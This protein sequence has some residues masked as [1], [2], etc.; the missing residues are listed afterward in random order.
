MLEISNFP[1][2]YSYEY[3]QD[4]N[5]D[6]MSFRRVICDFLEEDDFVNLTDQNGVPFD[7]EF[8]GT[9]KTWKRKMLRNGVHCDHIFQ[10]LTADYLQRNIVLVSALSKDGHDESGE[11]RIKS[12]YPVINNEPLY[13]LYYHEGSFKAG[14]FQSIRPINGNL[15][16]DPKKIHQQREKSFH[17]DVCF[18]RF[19]TSINLKA[20]M[21]THKGIK[22]FKCVFC[23]KD[24]IQESFW[25]DHENR[26]LLA[27]PLEQEY[28][29]YRFH[30]GTNFTFTKS[31]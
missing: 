22:K 9:T 4:Y 19:W 14:H 3:D 23:H 29:S 31:F 6:V 11:I 21:R 5:I 16:R 30:N 25:K 17:C 28:Y 8:Y 24:F 12:N 7:A 13:L 26:C 10:Q 2:F 1:I 27:R 18:Q 20:H 15:N